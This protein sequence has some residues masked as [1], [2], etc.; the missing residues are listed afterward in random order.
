MN[1]KVKKL[2]IGGAV[3]VTT[4]AGVSVLAAGPAQGAPAATY[5]GGLWIEL[6]RDRFVA[7]P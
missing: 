5:N 1:S 6:Q 7:P 2:A 4:A 3:A